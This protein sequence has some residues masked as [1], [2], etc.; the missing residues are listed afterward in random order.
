MTVAFTPNGNGTENFNLA[1]DS[2]NYIAALDCFT[3]SY[4]SALWITNT[5]A[6]NVVYVSAGWDQYNTEAI[7][8]V[9]GTPGA[10]LPVMPGSSVI[11]SINTTQQAVPGSSAATIAPLYIAGAVTGTA[12][13]IVQ[14]G[15]VT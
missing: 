15:S 13:I 4:G 2:T 10:G 6:A 3:G 14:Q 12:T 1:D 11:I 8:P 7:V 9:V 5:D